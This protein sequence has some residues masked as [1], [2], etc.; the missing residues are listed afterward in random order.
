MWTKLSVVVTPSGGGPSMMR[1]GHT[2]SILK[3][4]NGEWVVA[5]DANMLAPVPP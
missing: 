3:K 2:L 4:H 1:A 5:R